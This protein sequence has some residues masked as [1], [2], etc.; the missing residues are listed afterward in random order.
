MKTNLTKII[1]QYSEFHPENMKLAY[2]TEFLAIHLQYDIKVIDITELLAKSIS[3]DI[4]LS[5]IQYTDQDELK[6]VEIE[7]HILL[8]FINKINFFEFDIFDLSIIKNRVLTEFEKNKLIDIYKYY[9]KED[10]LEALSIK[11]DNISQNTSYDK[12][13]S[14]MNEINS[15]FFK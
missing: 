1:Q 11:K 2:L 8:K 5:T 14:T 9:E 15:Y 7:N 12:I 10:F 3:I 13:Y 4:Y 6:M